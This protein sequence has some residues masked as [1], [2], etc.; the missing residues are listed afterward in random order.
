MLLLLDTIFFRIRENPGRLLRKPLQTYIVFAKA[1]ESTA[2]GFVQMATLTQGLEAIHIH[3]DLAR[4]LDRWTRDRVF[5]NRVRI[6]LR[7][8]AREAYISWL[9]WLQ[10]SNVAYHDKLILRVAPE[11][12]QNEFP[13]THGLLEDLWYDFPVGA[14]AHAMKSKKPGN[15]LR[16]EHIKPLHMPV[17]SVDPDMTNTVLDH[18]E[19]CKSTSA[20]PNLSTDEARNEYVLNGLGLQLARGLADDN[21][22]SKLDII[23]GYYGSSVPFMMLFDAIN[24]DPSTGPDRPQNWVPPPPP[25]FIQPPSFNMNF[26]Q[27][28]PQAPPNRDAPYTGGGGYRAGDQGRG[29]A[30]DWRAAENRGGTGGNWRGRGRGGGGGGGG[31]NWS[32]NGGYRPY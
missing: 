11:N 28:V 20:V 4:I 31:R 14:M 9:A 27:N 10:T 18:I 21:E 8:S 22:G 3:Q 12:A 15:P 2:A 26:A 24:K 1:I 25:K 29:T 5:T 19:E 13:N 6:G 32:G 17:G 16:L 7:N 23:E 30:A